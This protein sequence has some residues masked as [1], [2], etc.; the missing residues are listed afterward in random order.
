[1][2]FS[3]E[4]NAIFKKCFF[5]MMSECLE[6]G[7]QADINQRRISFTQMPHIYTNLSYCAVR[8]LCNIPR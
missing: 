7:R 8:L 4:K 6:E 1:M 3:T 2:P 5:L